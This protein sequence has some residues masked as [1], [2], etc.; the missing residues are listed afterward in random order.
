MDCVRSSF[1]EIQNETY[2][3][4]YYTSPYSNGNTVDSCRQA[5]VT[6]A[7]CVMWQFSPGG[8]CNLSDIVVGDYPTRQKAPSGTIS[9]MVRCKKQYNALQ[10]VWWLVILGAVVLVIWYFLNVYEPRVWA[11]GES[12]IP[13]LHFARSA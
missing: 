11:R 13:H 9:G 2:S 10:T 6:S 1:D 5:C 7:E 3:G 4:S 12:V 8:Q